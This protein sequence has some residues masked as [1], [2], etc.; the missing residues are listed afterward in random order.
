M[1]GVLLGQLTWPAVSMA[2]T[3]D[4]NAA[5]S[6]GLEEIV[7]TATRRSE[8]LQDVPI[9]VLALSQEKMDAQGLKNIDDLSRLSPGLSFQ[10]NGIGSA[11]NDEGSDI[12]IRGVDSAAGTSTTGIYIDDTPV[13]T[14]HISFGN[15][16][17][18]PALFDLD[19]VEVLRGPQGTLFGAG[20]EGGVVRFIAPEPDLGKTTGYARADVAT[21]DGG[22]PSYEGGVA[23]GAPIIDDV[24]AFRFSVSYRRDGGWVDRVGYTLSPNAFVPLPA[25]IYSDTTDANANWQETATARLAVKWKVND[26][27]EITPSIYYQRLYINDTAAYWVALSD[28]SQNVYRNGNAGTN[29]SNDPFTL[30]AIKL[31]WDL[32]GASLFSNTSFYD[33]NQNAT[34]DYTQFL[35][36]I[37]SPFLYPN[38]F[39]APGDHGYTPLQ[40][41]QRN[42]YQEIRVASS[43][44]NARFVWSGGL[45]YSHLKENIAEDVIDPTFNP[46]IINYTSVYPF[47]PISFCDPSVPANACP[48]GRLLSAPVQEVVDKQVAVFGEASFKLTDTFKA[49]AGLRVSRL[50]YS[51]LDI[52]T[53]P[54]LG[55]TI[56]TASSGTER[57]VTP[58]AALS[59]QP[60]R[61]D[62]VYISASKGFRPGGPN[63]PVGPTCAG[64]LASLGLTQVPGQYGSDS[65]WSYE[66][67]SKNTFFDHR[68]QIDS[69]LFLVDWSG[70][71]QNVYLPGCGQLYTANLGKARSEGGDIEVLYRP[72]DVLTF[73]FTAAY[74]D[75]RL[76]K[77]SCAGSQSSYDAASSSCVAAGGAAA[78]PVASDGDALLGAPWSFTA[79]SEYHFPEWQGR[80]PYFRVDFQHSTAQKSLLS[81]QNPKNALFDNTIPGLPVVN[82]LSL[83]AGLRFSGFDL[84]AYANNVTNAHPLLLESRD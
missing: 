84:S 64:N 52:V 34:S 25:P 65:L 45:F 3:G 29:S 44:T 67:G 80:V 53:G 38:T 2:A 68:L 9:S 11:Y 55:T 15:V 48:G 37:V 56:N 19:R 13:Q 1:L 59:W 36:A 8:R 39:P 63:V 82:N 76:T 47:G 21:T 83:R 14:R 72:I 31:K 77:T 57:P 18:F 60:D 30:S 24:L 10:R 4:T 75:A 79:S 81:G 22:S 71:Q 69:S 12:N 6:S 74:T 54:L 43:D 32:G 23:I 58:K 70:I 51:G 5:P 49:T 35:R 50:D 40:D 42:F 46:E 17:A 73:D 61:D 28:P 78:R 62:L 27:L 16:N 7:V 41:T 66:I 33:R 20:A 26:A